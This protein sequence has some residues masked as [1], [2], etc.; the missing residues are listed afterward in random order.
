MLTPR[1]SQDSNSPA[2]APST[3]A[4]GGGAAALTLRE[5]LEHPCVAGHDVVAGHRGLERLVRDVAVLDNEDLDQ[6]R[7]GQLL[8]SNAYSLLD[9]NLVHLVSALQRRGAVALGIK[10]SDFW[11]APPGPLVRASNSYGF[12]LLVLPEG[13][14][15]QIIN[16]LLAWIS[17]RQVAELERSAE[18]H[19]RL[20]RAAVDTNGDAHS[21]LSLLDQAIGR[22]VAVTSHDGVVLWHT[23]P[24]GC[25]PASEM[26]RV[27]RRRRS[28]FTAIEGEPAIV[29]AVPGSAFPRTLVIARGVHPEDVLARAAL[30]HAAIVIGMLQI[31]RR[32]LN[33]VHRR[34]SRELLED[35][36]TGRLTDAGMIHTRAAWLGWSLDT[37]YVVIAARCV[38]A[39]AA[40]RRSTECDAC[41]T[42]IE[43]ALR[44]LRPLR[45]SVDA[46]VW[47][48]SSAPGPAAVVSLR[49]DVDGANV[50]D[51]LRD[52]ATHARGCSQT[53][54]G[55]SDVRTDLSNL[56]PAFLEAVL[57]AVTLIS[58]PGHATAQGFRDLGPMRL[59]AHATDLELMAA[60][61]AE[62]LGHMATDDSESS[63]ELLS[64]LTAL[65]GHSMRLRATADDAYFHYNTIRHRFARIRKELGAMLDDPTGRLLVSLAV[66][67]VQL[68]RVRDDF[69]RVSQPPAVE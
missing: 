30:A 48:L 2:P 25:W 18:L 42:T 68:L 21:V 67:A 37:P 14:F 23:G 34:F 41:A 22:R 13:P 40:C 7:M 50:A 47:Q 31:E 26:A 29:V 15:F 24:S 57:A 44:Q 5:V 52:A 39:G 19:D 62:V 6:I 1:A 51:V 8:L 9:A 28:G 45:R 27:A 36:A 55:V 4:F 49:D 66:Q 65:A 17:E 43:A 53:A 11:D 35:L 46:A 64:T 38:T 63:T 32:Q 33:D 59:L 20:L 3:T 58:A 16:P 56:R 10:L 12:P 54:I 61:A 60:S 69:L